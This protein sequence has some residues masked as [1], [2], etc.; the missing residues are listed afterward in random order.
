MGA[1]VGVPVVRV[2]PSLD[3][4]SRALAAA[5]LSSAREAIV[6]RG[7]FHLVLS[8]G[9]TPR[10]LYER[11]GQGSPFPWRETEVYFGDERAVSPR[12]P[13]SNYAMARKAFLSR[14]PIPRRQVHRLRGELSP[15]SR[16]AREY[17]ELL[18]QGA[19]PGARFDLVL[20]GIGRDGHTA[21]LFPDAP[22]LAVRDRWVVP[23]RR[24]GQPPFV[25]RL[26]LT[27]PALASSRAVS[28]LVAGPDKA[29]AIRGIFASLP[30][31]TP[32]FPA[33]LVRSEGPVTWF[34]DREAAEGLPPAQVSPAGRTVKSLPSQRSA[35]G[36][37]NVKRMGD[38]RSGGTSRST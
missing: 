12:S 37:K 28:F 7:R 16:A 29:P 2:F 11:W 30:R 31:G 1:G 5:I 18:R 22:A 33:S 36:Q 32:R 9:S 10:G 15:G 19:G 17:E 34:L 14:V 4:A 24:A 3:R 27:L 35:S 13:E 8:G 25:P 21:S 6:R 23:V 26:T 20:L 38:L